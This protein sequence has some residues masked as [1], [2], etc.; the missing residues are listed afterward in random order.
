MT[1]PDRS[2]ELARWLRLERTPGVGL[3]TAR[4]L[5]TAFGLPENIFAASLAELQ[6]VVTDR[7]ARALLTPPDAETQALMART[8][9]WA[10]QP[11]NHVL[12]LADTHYP[13]SLLDIADPP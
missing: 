7:V 10:V 9:E 12:T 4:K 5:L 11:G 6:A 13:K 1:H 3:D 2:Q 8:Q